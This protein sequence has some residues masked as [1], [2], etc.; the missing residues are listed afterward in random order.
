M[1]TREAQVRHPCARSDCSPH[2]VSTKNMHPR[3][4]DRYFAI[5]DEGSGS[6][7]AERLKRVLDR[8]GN[9][10]G[11]GDGGLLTGCCALR[12]AHDAGRGTSHD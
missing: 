4:I 11:A 12:G 1:V 6:V 9:P 2:T 10:P 8:M 7:S 3:D 5:F